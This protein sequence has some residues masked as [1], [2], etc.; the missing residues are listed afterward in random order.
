MTDLET[1]R[2]EAQA[3]IDAMTSAWPNRRYNIASEKERAP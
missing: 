3:A 2:A 1:E